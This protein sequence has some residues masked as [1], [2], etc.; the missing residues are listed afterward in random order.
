M[1]VGGQ[2]IIEGVLMMGK[3]V[4]IAVKNQDGNVI[5]EELS[6]KVPSNS[7]MFKIPLIRGLISVY[8][9]LYY[10]ILALNRSAEIS[11]GQKMKKSETFWS[12]V[13][14]VGLAV[15]LFI[16]LPTLL[17]NLIKGLKE[18]EFLF[19]LFEGIV[20]LI[21]FLIYVY[22]ISFMKDVKRIFQYH[23]AEHMV[24]NAYESGEKLIAENVRKYST[25]HPRCGT[26]FV[27]IVLI[28]S[29]VLFSL[30]GLIRSNDLLW[31]ILTRLVMLPVV[32][33][34][35]YE[36]LRISSKG[37]KIMKILTAPGLLLQKLTTAIPDDSQIEVALISLKEALKEKVNT[38]ASGIEFL[39]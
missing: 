15:G 2:A 26:S 7:K 4:V 32:V 14:A 10:G 30:F 19:S 39:G 12:I 16:V 31:R 35:S 38:D 6:V 36:I 3:R 33:A 25:I 24:I 9:S 5:V 27:M 29:I 23:G 17:I 11:T 37:S 1:K 34:F 21:F 28:V 22:I 8:Y 18:N 13:L 20:R